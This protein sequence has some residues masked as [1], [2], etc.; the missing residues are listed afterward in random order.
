MAEM[1]DGFRVLRG[2]AKLSDLAAQSFKRLHFALT[3]ELKCS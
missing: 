1:L 2:F 3:A